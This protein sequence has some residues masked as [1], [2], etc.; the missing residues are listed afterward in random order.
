[1]NL[2]GSK[3]PESPRRGHGDHLPTLLPINSERRQ[4]NEKQIMVT[5]HAS[6]GS[7]WHLEL[8]AISRELQR[9]LQ[10]PQFVASRCDSD[11]S[12]DLDPHELKQAALVY[13]ISGDCSQ[14]TLQQMDGRQRLSKE[15]FAK[16]VTSQSPGTRPIRALDAI[17]CKFWS[18]QGMQT[19]I[20]KADRLV[21]LLG[22]HWALPLCEFE[23]IPSL[24]VPHVL[25][26]GAIPHSLRGMALG[27]LQHL[28]ALFVHTGWLAARSTWKTQKPF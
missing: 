23:P 8:L 14:A 27:Q 10:D 13:G 17:V 22:S 2:V 4:T 20:P 1:M 24:E 26:S 5:C 16:M 7:M 3:Q 19:R 9:K 25:V 18:W 12:R 28:E 11:G 15:S 6:A 21:T